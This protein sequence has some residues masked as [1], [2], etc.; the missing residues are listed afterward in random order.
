MSL[1]LGYLIEI[2]R[3]PKNIPKKVQN[4]TIIWLKRNGEEP[5]ELPK[6]APTHPMIVTEIALSSKQLYIFED[7]FTILIKFKIM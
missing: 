2:E 5:I 6:I 7:V 4:G 1:I 3:K